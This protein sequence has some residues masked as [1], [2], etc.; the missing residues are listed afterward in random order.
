MVFVD[1]CSF[2]YIEQRLFFCKFMY[3]RLIFIN[4][5]KVYIYFYDKLKLQEVDL[6]IIY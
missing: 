3:K 2:I 1:I 6:W 4:L 5:Y